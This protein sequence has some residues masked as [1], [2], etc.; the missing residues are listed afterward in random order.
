MTTDI[1]A[2]AAGYWQLGGDLPVTRMGFGTMRLPNWPFG[3]HTD[4]EQ[5]I[6]VLR[7][8]VELGVN[9][10][11]TAAFYA[12]EGMT[13]NQLIRQALHPYPEELVIVTKVGPL[14]GE[15]GAITG[16]MDE[17]REGLHPDEL[18]R[19]VEANLGDLG[20]D[21]LDMVNLRVGGRGGPSDEPVGPAFEALAA[22]REEGLIRHLGISN[23]APDRLAEAQRIAPV[24]SVQNMF[25]ISD[26]GDA[27]MLDLATEQGVCYV[28]YFPLGGHNLID[29]PVVAEVAARHGATVAQ[30]SLAWLL[31]RSPAILLIP[32]TSSIEHLEQNIAAAGLKL[33][34][35]DLA[36]LEQVN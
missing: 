23:V 21:R 27:H 31:H 19:A 25:N 7:R 2:T 12:H 35:E 24:A 3:P 1:S 36:S 30:I 13:A 8:A 15:A 16:P 11:D 9:H 17:M 5:A 18:R 22:L 14:Y 33:T 32:G 29:N 20:V 4:P 34:E 28:P 6:A 10:I 26:R